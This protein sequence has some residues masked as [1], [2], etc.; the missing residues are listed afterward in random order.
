MTDLK[1][2]GEKV[3][4]HARRVDEITDELRAI[5]RDLDALDPELRQALR[6][7]GL[8]EHALPQGT[9][10]GLVNAV[11]RAVTD[12]VAD[13]QP[14]KKL[15]TVATILDKAWGRLLPVAPEAGPDI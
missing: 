5:C 2:T 3:L 8:F 9:W 12:A 15:P 6:D 14:A 1:T 7:R 4:A 13:A 11:R 10:L